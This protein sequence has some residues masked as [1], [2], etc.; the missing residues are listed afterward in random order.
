M[1]KIILNKVRFN[2]RKMTLGKVTLREVMSHQFDYSLLH[3]FSVWSF[4][5]GKINHECEMF[6]L[7]WLLLSYS[8]FALIVIT[9]SQQFLLNTAYVHVTLSYLV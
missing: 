8:I 2:P 7:I 5:F 3:I 4:V 1:Q 9:A 6:H